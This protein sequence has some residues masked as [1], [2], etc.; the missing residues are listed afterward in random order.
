MAEFVLGII[1]VEGQRLAGIQVGKMVGKQVCESIRESFKTDMIEKYKELAAAA[2]KTI[3]E[4][5]AEMK[6]LT[7]VLITTFEGMSIKDFK[8]TSNDSNITGMVAKPKA[9]GNILTGST[10][11]GGAGNATNDAPGQLSNAA[12]D[13]ANAAAHD[14]KNK[15]TN[16]ANDAANA[17]KD[18]ANAA[19][20][21]MQNKLANLI[22]N[23]SPIKLDNPID[24]L[25]GA[26]IIKSVIQGLKPDEGVVPG[27]LAEA[28]DEKLVKD[29][30]IE[31]FGNFIT[32]LTG[33]NSN[34]LKK[35]FLDVLKEQINEKFRSPDGDKT[36]RETIINII[37][38]KCIKKCDPDSGEC[39]DDQNNITQEPIQG[40]MDIPEPIQEESNNKPITEESNNKPIQEESKNEPIQEESKNEPLKVPTTVE[41]IQNLDKNNPLNPKTGEVI[42]PPPPPQEQIKGG[43]YN[44]PSKRFTRKI[45]K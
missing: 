32:E 35:V 16:A 37:Q 9:I 33:K 7:D 27:Y 21:G 23:G 22:P 29:K 25:P 14:A 18:A 19:A 30:M 10:S 41:I 43:K 3:L 40:S 17:A 20:N 44:K 8:L 13:A 36:F 31:G 4:N 39:S 6:K 12:N 1:G 42:L 2:T 38:K 15:L 24:A 34:D 11:T 45:L 28:L 26:K 5:P